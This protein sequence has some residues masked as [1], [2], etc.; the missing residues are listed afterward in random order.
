VNKKLHRKKLL[1]GTG[2]TVIALVMSILA[3]FLPRFPGDLEIT[4]LFQSIHSA[5]LLTAMKGIS[6]VTGDWRA[7]VL[8]I[9]SCLVIWRWLGRREALLMAIVGL[10]TFIDDALK[11]IINRPRPAPDLVTIYV[12]ET[13]K[14]FPSGHSF[15]VMLVFGMLAYLAFTHLKKPGLKILALSVFVILILWTGASRIYLGVHWAS[16]VAGGYIIGGWFLIALIWLY[17]VFKP[18]LLAKAHS[19]GDN[20]G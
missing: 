13:A 4:R 7:A 3:H 6:Y 10:S 18:R 9:I 20:T 17:R 8:V 11:I 2:L 12:D 1:F 15:F 5:G 16:D 14:S 19:L